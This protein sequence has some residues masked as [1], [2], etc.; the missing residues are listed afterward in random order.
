MI[1]YYKREAGHHFVLQKGLDR[2]KKLWYSDFKIGKERK[3]G[4][5]EAT[6]LMVH[7]NPENA[8]TFRKPIAALDSLCQKSNK[9]LRIVVMDHIGF[10]YSDDATFEMVEMHHSYNLLQLVDHLQF[11][12]KEVILT[13]HD[14]GG[15]IG[16]GTMLQRAECVRGVVIMNTTVF[17]F[18]V[19]ESDKLSY[20]N[21][22]LPSYFSWAGMAELVPDSFWGRHSA[23]A[24]FAQPSEGV[25]LLLLKYLRFVVFGIG[26]ASSRK[27][28]MEAE[29]LY[30]QQFER[31]TMNARSSRRMVRQTPVWGRGYSYVDHKN[32]LQDNHS[33]YL[34]IQ[35]EI[36]RKWANVPV[37]MVLGHDDPLAKPSVLHQWKTALPQTESQV[38]ENVGHFVSEVKGT[39]V[40]EAIHSMLEKPF[41]SRM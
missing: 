27:D 13:I 37:S 38:F 30:R 24:I 19:S 11:K 5:S 16:V 3:D 34:K 14:W 36:G 32:G 7:G 10:G 39:E 31:N 22:P 6:L 17:P 9:T 23:M 41:P 33:F 12:E 15:P 20:S 28:D 35:N 8:N 2:N 25:I 18:P 29:A 4:Y 26:L 40:A 1:D 21:Y